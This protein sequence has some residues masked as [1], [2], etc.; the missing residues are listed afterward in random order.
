MPEAVT[1]RTFGSFEPE[2]SV[3]KN[4]VHLVK[5]IVLELDFLNFM[6]VKVWK[7]SLFSFNY[8]F[9]FLNIIN[10]ESTNINEVRK[11]I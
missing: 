8:P 5:S 7:T 2:I 6:Q 1:E 10:S 9:I 3:E 4:I 11:N